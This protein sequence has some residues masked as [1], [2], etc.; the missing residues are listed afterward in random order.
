[1]DVKWLE[2]YAESAEESL[3]QENKERLFLVDIVAVV[4]NASVTNVK[5]LSLGKRTVVMAIMPVVVYVVELEKFLCLHR[6]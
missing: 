6:R 2:V 1:M 3:N 5:R 4:V